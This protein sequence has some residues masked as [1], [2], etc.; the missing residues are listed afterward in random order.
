S[1]TLRHPTPDATPFPYTTLF[2]STNALGCGSQWNRKTWP[3]DNCAPRTT[4]P[5]ALQ[6]SKKSA[7]QI[8]PAHCCRTKRSHVVAEAFLV[9]GKRTPVGRH[10][11]ALSSLRP[12]DMAATAI[13]AVLAVSGLDSNVVDAVLLGNAKGVGEE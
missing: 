2:R 11:G 5:K 7:N 8:L 10:S 1:L 3:R 12:D 9:S 13:K 6:P 4:T